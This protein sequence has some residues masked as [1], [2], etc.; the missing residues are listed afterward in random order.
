M[1]MQIWRYMYVHVC[2]YIH[3][4]TPTR[5]AFTFDMRIF[6]RI[7][8]CTYMYTCICIHAHIYIHIQYTFIDVFV[9]VCTCTHAH[10]YT[11]HIDWRFHICIYMYTC[12]QTY[13]TH[14]ITYS[15]MYTHVHM[16]IRIPFPFHTNFHL[17][18][19]I[20]F[21]TGIH[22]HAPT[23][24]VRQYIYMKTYMYTPHVYIEYITF[25]SCPPTPPQCT[26][27]GSDE[28]RG[29]GVG[30]GR[31]ILRGRESARKWYNH[32]CGAIADGAALATT[33]EQGTYVGPAAVGIAAIWWSCAGSFALTRPL[34]HTATHCNTLQ[35][36]TPHCNALQH[37]AT[38]CNTLQH[39]ATHCDTL[40]TLCN[41]LQLGS[42]TLVGGL[43]GLQVLLERTRPLQHTATHPQCTAKQCNAL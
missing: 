28:G 27:H 24:K 4:W 9:Y 1:Y 17:R 2:M 5:Y 14:S 41:K 21:C 29:G 12:T 25:Y 26:R 19:R 35:C 30:G 10:T 31:F 34:Q 15:Y 16:H 8:L 37:T 39:T 33:A 7:Y 20:Y 40:V 18:I 13:S 23:K 38:L 43:Q 11:I 36:T 22:A 42:L 32:N 6:L 3:L